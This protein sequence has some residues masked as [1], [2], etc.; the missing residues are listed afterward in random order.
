MFV[1]VIKPFETNPVL[2]HCSNFIIQFQF[3]LP[4]L[5]QN[6]EQQLLQGTMGLI[7]SKQ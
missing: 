7:C 2:V 5:Q 1:I 3:L 4:E 6:Y